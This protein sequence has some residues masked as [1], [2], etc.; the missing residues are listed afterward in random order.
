MLRRLSRVLGVWSLLIAMLTLV[1]DA[2]KTLGGGG[3]II[4]TPLAAEWQR[5]FPN[6]FNAAQQAI[7]MRFGAGFWQHSI[8]P[9][10]QGPTWLF[11]GVLGILLYWLGQKRRE[12]EIF[13]N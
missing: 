1:V 11:F 10:L 13:T 6:S 8:V 7:D 5:L 4:V 12:L 2:T 3:A 9:I